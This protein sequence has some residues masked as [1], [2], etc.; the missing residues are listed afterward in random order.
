MNYPI[1]KIKT[2]DNIDL[3]GIISDG[4]SEK[5]LVLIN[6]HGT[7]SS[8]YD[9][10]FT[11]NLFAE[12]P[13]I[14]VGVLF[15]N[16]RGNHVMEAFQNAGAALEKFEDCVLDI[17]AWIKFALDRGYKRVILQGHSLGTEKAVYYM[18]QGKYVNAIAGVILLAFSD[19]FGNQARIA[20]KFPVDPMIE[21]KEL[22]AQGKGGQFITSVWRP[23]GGGVPKSADSYLNF[24]SP[25][26]ELS[27]ALPIRQGGGL[28][29][30][31]EIKVPVLAIVGDK[32]PFTY[33][34]V[35]EATALLKRENPLTQIK[36]IPDADHDFTN[37][38]AEL[39]QA[40]K[41][42]IKFNFY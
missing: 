11:K 1:V 41:D 17:D 2:A 34:S 12:L 3:H 23:H 35:P 14:G 31:R 25:G 13:A 37:K 15:T 20:E 28:K 39:T 27:K 6:I 8:F 5:D 36:I 22:A 40:I 38:E 10:D 26:S 24:F 21:A 30:Y 19:S 4:G 9:E 32:D 18:S 29:M 33:L 16:N 42:H 7:A